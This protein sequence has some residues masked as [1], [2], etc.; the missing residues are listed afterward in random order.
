MKSGAKVTLVNRSVEK[1]EKIAK[2]FGC[3]FAPLE[4]LSDLV[5][6]AKVVVSTLPAGV[7]VI[8]DKW[9]TPDHVLFDANYH[10]KILKDKARRSGATFIGGEAWLMHQ[11]IPAYRYFTGSQRKVEIPKIVESK[12]SIKNI[13]LVGFMGAGKSSVGT[14]L[15]KL[16]DWEYIDTDEKIVLKTDKSVPQIFSEL[17]EPAFRKIEQETIQS[18]VRKK[19][20]V[21]SCG[22]GI[23]L[24]PENRRQLADNCLTVW[25]YTPVKTALSRIDLTS[26]PLLSLNVSDVEAEAEKIFQLRKRMVRRVRRSRRD[27]RSSIVSENGGNNL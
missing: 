20:A 6:N 9:L 24:D 1:A 26:R 11:A 12:N 4:N 17:G 22:G 19:H 21:I 27:Q 10:S 13:A 16:L 15:A 7:D 25:I 23:V 5:K 8:A 14:A 3:E 18:V 2:A